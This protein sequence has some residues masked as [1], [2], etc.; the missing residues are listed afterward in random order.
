MKLEQQIE[1]I[2][3]Y[4]NEPVSLK[5]LCDVLDKNK[6]EIKQGIEKLKENLADRGLSLVDEGESYMLA[7]SKE[8]SEL[9]D[10]IAK[11]ELSKDI[12]K[13][14][15]ETLAVILYKRGATRR[16]VDYI[17]GVNSTFILRNLLARGLVERREG[18]QDARVFIYQPTLALLAH[19]GLEN[20]NKLPE[21]DKV[22]GEIGE[23]EKRDEA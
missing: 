5:K 4:K 7:T 19:L 21:Y 23:L 16:E 22:R 8:S 6:E 14:G 1:S 9:L 3:F 10:K 20:A 18:R 17:R 13:A 2:L 12:G 11:D 15:L